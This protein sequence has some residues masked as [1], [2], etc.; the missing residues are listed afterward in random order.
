MLLAI[1]TSGEVERVER[2]AR[3]PVAELQTPAPL[4][5]AALLAANLARMA[6]FQTRSAA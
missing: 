1:K 6:Q 4:V 5:D 2:T 3:T